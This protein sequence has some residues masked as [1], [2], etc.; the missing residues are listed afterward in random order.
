ME[1]SKDQ[2]QDRC[3]RCLCEA[4]RENNSTKKKT[5]DR[6]RLCCVAFCAVNRHTS[7][8]MRFCMI[9]P[10]LVAQACRCG[11][12]AAPARLHRRVP[13]RL[14][15]TLSHSSSICVRLLRSKCIIFEH[16]IQFDS[17]RA[18]A[19]A[20]TTQ[21]AQVTWCQRIWTAFRAIATALQVRTSVSLSRVFELDDVFL[22]GRG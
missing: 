13:R 22:A 16:V 20:V 18:Q 10:L 21:A 17:L 2:R 8:S 6:V 19:A 5:S 7:H 14:L 15:N 11:R 4:S 3:G 9:Q 1:I 12:G